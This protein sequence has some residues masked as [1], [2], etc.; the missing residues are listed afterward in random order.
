VI[1]CD[2]PVLRRLLTIALG[3]VVLALSVLA[4]GVPA[5]AATQSGAAPECP[6]LTVEESTKNAR[7]VFSGIVTAVEK[8]SRT[9][10]L[11]GAIYDQTVTVDLVYQGNIDTETVQVQTDRNHLQCSLGELVTGAEYMFFVT[12]TPW[13]ASGVSGTRVSDATVVA[14][15]EAVLG[16]GQP[17]VQPAPEKAVFS[18]VDTGAPETLS[19]TAAPGAA[20]V[21]IG[22]LGLLLVRGLGR[23]SR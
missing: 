20:L 8:E 2:A 11:P 9:D 1:C 7:A 19:R 5:P 14:Q 12:G 10:G 23:R 13:F 17:P 22:L 21:L 3:V 16:A 15:V 4:V 6:P 18:A